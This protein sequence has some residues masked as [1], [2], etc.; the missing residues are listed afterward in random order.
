M[1]TIHAQPAAAFQEGLNDK[2]LR[3]APNLLLMFRDDAHLR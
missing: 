2:A 1:V 3:E